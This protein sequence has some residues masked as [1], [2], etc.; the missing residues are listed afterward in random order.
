MRR[1]AANNGEQGGRQ[2]RSWA[3]AA[4]VNHYIQ[5]RN[6]NQREEHRTDQSECDGAPQRRPHT[7]TREDHRRDA[8]RGRHGCQKD[9][10]QSALAGFNRRLLD[11]SAFR[12]SGPDVVDQDDGIP[13]YHAAQADDAQERGESEGISCDQQSK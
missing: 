10:P 11:P 7:R 2:D 12:H 5:H 3:G 8:D 4:L 6:H 13:N 1:D 9:G